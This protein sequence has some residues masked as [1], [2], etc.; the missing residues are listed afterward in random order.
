MI[1][2]DDSEEVKED[3]QHKAVN[4]KTYCNQSKKKW[5]DLQIKATALDQE[6]DKKIHEL[7]NLCS[8][9]FKQMQGSSIS[10][11]G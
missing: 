9:M 5:V 2:E 6:Y 4:A 8:S 10:E 3:H 11:A 1:K 7:G